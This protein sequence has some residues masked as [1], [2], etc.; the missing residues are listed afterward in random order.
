MFHTYH[1]RLHQQ[2][3]GTDAHRYEAGFLLREMDRLALLQPLYT[4]N[5]ASPL[6]LSPIH[7]CIALVYAHALKYE[8]PG[9]VTYI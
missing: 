1:I 2:L 6:S 4:F 9:S 5:T 3:T 8:L 7:I